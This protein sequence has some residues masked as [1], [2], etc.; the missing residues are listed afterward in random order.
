[1]HDVIIAG[2]TI[3]DGTGRPKFNGDV[4]FMDARITRIGS[5][6]GSAG[7]TIS[8]DGLLVMPAC[9]RA[10][11]LRWAGVMG[12]TVGSLLMAWRRH[13]CGSAYV[14]RARMSA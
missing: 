8:A 7:R 9:G 1:M 13:G 10:Y 6:L 2:G 5:D 14:M 12:L 11:A 4:A 3:V